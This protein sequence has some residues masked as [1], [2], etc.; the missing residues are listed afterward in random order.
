MFL[1][2]EG[3]FS[4]ASS[5][6]LASKHQEYTTKNSFDHCLLKNGR[7]RC[8]PPYFLPRALHH[9]LFSSSSSYHQICVALITTIPRTKYIECSRTHSR[10]TI[11]AT[12][13]Y[14]KPYST[15]TVHPLPCDH[16]RQHPSTSRHNH[17]TPPRPRRPPIRLPAS[18]KGHKRQERK[19]AM[20]SYWM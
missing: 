5:I 4:S 12:A 2:Y 20:P 16:S 17:G 18:Q 19:V 3:E 13:L 7:L 10:T 6:E 14:H 15:P 9:F 1:C 11:F 8:L